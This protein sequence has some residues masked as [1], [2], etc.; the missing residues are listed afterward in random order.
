MAMHPMSKES[1]SLQSSMGYWVTRLARALEADFEKRLTE[2]GVT[3]ASWAVLSAIVHH[4]KT[5]PAELAAFIGIDGA[6]V[7]RHLD[8]IVKQGLVSRRRSAKDRR[9]IDLKVTAR[10]AALVPKIAAAS[11][12]TNEKF[13]AGLTQAES[14]AMQA[15]ILKMLSNS[16]VNPSDL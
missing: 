7:T 10:G 4:E 5:T 8:R 1:Y 11:M 14:E 12:A 13:L 16:D 9:S 3:R 6:A 15:T 2:H